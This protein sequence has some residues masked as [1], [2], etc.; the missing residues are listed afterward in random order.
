MKKTFITVFKYII[1]FLIIAAASY[2]IIWFITLEPD[3]RL[4]SQDIR[5]IVSIVDIFIFIIMCMITDLSC[6]ARWSLMVF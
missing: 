1:G 2:L 5:L 6:M 3:V 4:W